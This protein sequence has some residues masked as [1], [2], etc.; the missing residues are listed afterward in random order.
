MKYYKCKRCGFS[1]LRSEVR[2][3]LRQEHMIRRRSMSISGE[4]KE[5]K[6]TREMIVEEMG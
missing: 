1:G 4:K 5:S 6:I 2:S 3:H